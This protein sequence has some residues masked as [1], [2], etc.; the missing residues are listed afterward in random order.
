ML[1]IIDY[2]DGTHEALTAELEGG[3]V[4]QGGR[5]IPGILVQEP[6]R[7]PFKVDYFEAAL[8][9]GRQRSGEVTSDLE[10][11]ECVGF[12]WKII[13][14]ETDA[15]REKMARWMTALGSAFD[16][17][18]PGTGYL[19]EGLLRILSDEEAARYDRDRECWI[20]Y[21]SDPASEAASLRRQ[22]A[23]APAGRPARTPHTD[24][25]TNG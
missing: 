3:V 7:C 25:P 2:P 11:S 17:E 24:A 21:L 20:T 6:Q 22:R 18:A 8:N 1:L 12:R 19:H 5:W 9:E 14:G 16:P 13:G 10:D 4:A 23:A 15:C